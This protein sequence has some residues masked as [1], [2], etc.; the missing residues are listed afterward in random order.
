MD[1]YKQ[2]AIYYPMQL[3]SRV[4]G[5]NLQLAGS[6]TRVVGIVDALI[7]PTSGGTASQLNYYEETSFASNISGPFSS[8]SYTIVQ[9]W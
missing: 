7:F 9:N 4:S 3:T 1:N 8:T 6:G 2:M 5:T